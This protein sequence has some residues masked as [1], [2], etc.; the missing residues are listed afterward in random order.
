MKTLLCSLFLLVVSSIVCFSQISRGSFMIGGALHF[1]YEDSYYNDKNPRSNPTNQVYLEEDGTIFQVNPT[2]GYFV[3]NNVVVGLNPG[4]SKQTTLLTR[5]DYYSRF[6]N[7]SFSLSPF[8][9]YYASLNEKLRFFVHGTLFSYQYM[10]STNKE[11]TFDVTRETTSKLYSLSPSFRIQPGIVFFATKR[12]GI[13]AT[14]GFIGY[15]FTKS[16]REGTTDGNKF[17][18]KATD[19]NFQFSLNPASFNLGLQFYL[20]RK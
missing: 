11:Q 5:E 18:H 1:S 13:E 6:V 2:F 4:F 10:A 14:L 8:I 17:E 12:V 9:R 19:K 7:N 15:S 16:K 20:N 3:L